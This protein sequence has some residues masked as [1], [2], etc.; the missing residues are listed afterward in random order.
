MKRLGVLGAGSH[1]SKS[2]GPALKKLAERE[3]SRLELSAVCD[4]D[5]ARARA[6][7]E[8]F[9]FARAYT[10]AAEMVEREN[11]D[12]LLVISPVALTESLVSALLPC[13]IPLLI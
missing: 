11:L 5:E 4:L 6:Y 1:S 3:P 10:D 13:R 7:Q 12:G 8:K 9:G 2:H